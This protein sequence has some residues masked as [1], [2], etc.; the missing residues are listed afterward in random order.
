MDKAARNAKKDF[1]RGI[2]SRDL[3]VANDFQQTFSR[4]K[5]C[6]ARAD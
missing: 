1:S 2:R 5:K 3:I 4:E 6:C